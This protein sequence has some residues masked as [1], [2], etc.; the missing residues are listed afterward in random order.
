MNRSTT[1]VTAFMLIIGA[2]TANPA[3]AEEPRT[4]RTQQQSAS[5]QMMTFKTVSS[6]LG[7]DVLD[8]NGETVGT[9]DDIII[10][11]GDGRAHYAMISTGGFLGLGT[12]RFA[13]PFRQ[14]GFNAVDDVMTLN[15]APDALADDARLAERRGW[16][17]IDSG[18]WGEEI[19]SAE[20]R[21]R[22]GA[23]ST[24]VDPYEKSVKNAKADKLVGVVTDV[25]RVSLATG[26]EEVRVTM[27]TADD[28]ER[29]VVI[30][31]AW[32]AAQ[33]G[34]MPMRGD[35]VT[36]NAFKTKSSGDTLF[37][38]RDFDRRGDMTVLRTKDGE[39]MWD[40]RRTNDHS[41]SATTG[42]FI[43]V[44][45]VIGRS[46]MTPDETTLG[47][48]DDAVIELNSGRIAILS[49]DPNENFLGIGDTER[50]VPWNAV[51]VGDE[52]VNIDANR[53]TLLECAAM[54]STVNAFATRDRLAPVHDDDLAVVAE[55]EP[56]GR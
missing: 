44:A 35:E 15:V 34:A 14:L 52:M 43:S 40:R 33:K 49:F 53:E 54:P 13:V 6:L 3:L 37:V 23:T 29:T 47:E 48:I 24:Y 10:D 7:A 38:A 50:C 21:V 32:Y 20:A 25:E 27:A 51:S 5:V 9:I 30:G 8:T 26:I 56:R 55:V 31:P 36:I 45:D 2:G 17:K 41:A 12:D 22:S 46:A 4:P 19:A 16:L 42:R 39:V 18:T 28:G 11:R 1:L